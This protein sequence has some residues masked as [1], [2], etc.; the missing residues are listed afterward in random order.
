MTNEYEIDDNY[1][2]E[3]ER[4]ARRFSGALIGTSGALAGDVL[5]LLQ[6]VRRLTRRQPVPRDEVLVVA[7][8]GPINAGKSLVASMLPALHLQWA[9]PIYDGLSVMLGVSQEWL[10]NRAN[11]ETAI[12]WL[13]VSPRFLLRTLGT[14]WG[15]DLVGP[16]LWVRLTDKRIELAAAG[17]QRAFA[18]CGTRFPNEARVVR[19]RGG[20]VWWV[21]RGVSVSSAPQHRSDATLTEADCDRTIENTG[22]IDQ[23]RDAVEAAWGEYEERRNA[24]MATRATEATSN[25]SATTDG[26]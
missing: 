17:G 13:G 7:L 15:R 3:A 12:D 8:A 14:E 10:R 16:D 5:R 24:D 22:T 18:I 6:E 23:L 4:R 11:K 26:A 20:E 2:A 21:N 19:A 1:L 9:D 25:D